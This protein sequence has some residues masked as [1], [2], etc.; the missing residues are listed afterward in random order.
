MATKESIMNLFERYQANVKLYNQKCGEKNI[1]VKKRE[2]IL[3]ENKK[4]EE[5]IG[6]LDK[7]ALL[8]KMTSKYA[9]D[10]AKK[11]VEDLVSNCLKYIFNSDMNFKIEIKESVGRISADYYICESYDG[12]NY[13]YSPELSKGGGVV[14]IVSLALRM[15][16]LLKHSPKIKG[17]IILDEPAKHVSDDFVGNVADFLSTIS[18]NFDKQIIFITHNQGLKNIA[19]NCFEIIKQDNKSQ[20]YKV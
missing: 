12:K 15:G 8:L 4:Y 10:Q 16:F 1:L 2:D 17:P 3:K 19:Q 5:E 20:I 9:R 7:T 11:D 18:N 6:R 14:D 13:Y